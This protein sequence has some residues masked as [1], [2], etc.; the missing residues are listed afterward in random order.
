MEAEF[1]NSK[2]KKNEIANKQGDEFSDQLFGP[3]TNQAINNGDP[4]LE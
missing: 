1:I 2:N 3:L 4:A